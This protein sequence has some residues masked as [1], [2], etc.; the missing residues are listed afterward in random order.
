[1]ACL[2]LN[3]AVGFESSILRTRTEAR[4]GGGDESA[5]MPG[6]HKPR[7]EWTDRFSRLT[8]ISRDIE[9]FVNSPSSHIQIVLLPLVERYKIVQCQQQEV[10]E[11]LS[12][13]ECRISPVELS[14]LVSLAHY[15]LFSWGLTGGHEHLLLIEQR[16]KII[17]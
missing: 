12:D 17:D 7:Q 5:E 13:L 2:D 16:C 4:E 15:D 9:E 1:M 11:L 3:L 10:E 14:L 8:Q 6:L